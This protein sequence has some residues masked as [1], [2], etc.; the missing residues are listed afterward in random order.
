MDGVCK[1]GLDDSAMDLSASS[2][3]MS[4]TGSRTSSSGSGGT[5]S[6]PSVPSAPQKNLPPVLLLLDPEVP[7]VQVKRGVRYE[8]C[9]PGQDINGEVP[10]EPGAR[11]EDDADPSIHER[12]R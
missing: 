4:S 5:D 10:C 8:R 11:A 3:V 7:V 2:S 9:L 6:A 12:V 1:D